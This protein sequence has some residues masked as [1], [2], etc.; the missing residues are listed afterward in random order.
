MYD[1]LNNL[2]MVKSSQHR[3]NGYLLAKIIT[4]MPSACLNSLDIHYFVFL[5]DYIEIQYHPNFK[6]VPEFMQMHKVIGDACKSEQ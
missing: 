4:F 2:F 5:N 1:I 6:L 3:K